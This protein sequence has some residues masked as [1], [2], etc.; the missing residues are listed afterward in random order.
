LAC[1]TK[2]TIVDG[3]VAV[4]IDGVAH[5]GAWFVER[6]A[7]GGAAVK[8]TFRHALAAKSEFAGVAFKPAASAA[9]PHQLEDLV[10]EIPVVHPRRCRGTCAL[11]IFERKVVGIRA[12]HRM[13]G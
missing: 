10:I 5:F 12:Q 6:R 2:L 3:A 9:N 8:R 13:V 7:G 4:V 11:P 1:G